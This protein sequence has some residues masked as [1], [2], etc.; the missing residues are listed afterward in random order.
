MA[1]LVLRRARVA[2][3]AEPVDIAVSDGIITAVEPAL[4]CRSAAEIDCAARVVIPG[5]IEPHVH[6][7]KA[8][9]ATQAV[10]PDDTLAGAIAVTGELKRGFTATDVA[11]RA[12]R[13][14]DQA[15]VHG[16]TALRAH[17]D[18][19]PIVGLLGVDV[20]VD[21]RAEYRGLIDLQIV[22]FPQEGILRAPGTL[23][24]LRAALRR[25]ADVIGGCS[26]NEAD[27]AD[28][29]RH[30]DLVFELAA[31][32]DVPVDIH[33]DFADDATDPRFAMADYIAT[34]TE[35]AGLGGRVAIGHVTSLAG[36][37]PGER[38]A[39]MARLAEAGVAVVPLPA[40]DMHL[41]GRADETA[42]RRGIAPVRELWAAGVTTAY[43]S[44]NIRNAFTPYG[45][46]DLLDIGL[47]LAQT[48]HLGSPADLRRVLA[49]ATTEAAALL[50]IG[51]R[52]GIRVGARADLVVLGTHRVADALLD[53]P[54]RCYVVK[55]GR[56]VA[57]TTRTTEILRPAPVR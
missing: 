43:S 41:G 38:R 45:N 23:E 56:I 7:D 24:L 30:V 13:V 28:C 33:A 14:L 50:G 44:N 39:T 11:A 20:L 2:D 26:Y 21:L 10:A 49:M 48:G 51:D 17:P 5:L 46:A 8:L 40:T 22:A 15:I 53:R 18:V 32:F 34:A 55:A 37:P 47:F 29:E 57:R 25:G 19:D 54:D 31:E 35:R 16:T 36:R 52:H 6:L 12:R 9:L 1:D 42:V 3:D 27:V 4:R